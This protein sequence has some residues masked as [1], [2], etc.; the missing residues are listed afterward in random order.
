MENYLNES[1]TLIVDNFYRGL[2]IA[3][4]LL[5]NKTHIVGTLRNVKH[6]FQDVL[7]TKLKVGE[8]KG[9]ENDKGIVVN[10]WKDK[11][12]IRFLSTRRGIKI[13]NPEKKIEKAKKLK[14][15]NQKQQYFI[16]KTSKELIFWIKWQITIPH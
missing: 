6:C 11:R 2:H 16:I 9:K 3:H 13:L 7:N 10:I 8:I 5:N 15:K 1:R 14:K 4:I 12:D